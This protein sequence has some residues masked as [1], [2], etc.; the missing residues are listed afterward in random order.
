MAKVL[1]FSRNPSPDTLRE[2]HSCVQQGGVLSLITES[3]YAL[4][5]SVESPPAIDRIVN[6]KGDRQD[7]PI[8][9][10]IGEQAQLGPLISALPP[11]AQPLIDHFWPGP[12]TLVL[13]A[14]AQLPVPL[15]CG[16][17][18]IGVRQPRE[19]R[20]L[21]LLNIT[22]PLTGTS[23][24]RSGA[25]PL[26]HPDDV[27]RT[28]GNHIDLIVDAGM[29]PGGVPST[30]LSLVGEIRLLRKGPISAEAIR[31]V[32]STVGLIL[33]ESIE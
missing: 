6:M 4:A 22:G 16:T 1:H 32:L 29:A 26:Y 21:A 14:A 2:I 27:Q 3:S 10:L 13:P 18:T 15:T 31:E 25:S 11:G 12:L 28:F 23:A 9:V 30:V 8:L 5:A 20:L 7:K 17:G 33:Q 24:N 19:P